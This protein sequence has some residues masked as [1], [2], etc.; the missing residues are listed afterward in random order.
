MFSSRAGPVKFDYVRPAMWRPG[1]IVMCPPLF[2]RFF[3][4][5]VSVFR[6]FFVTASCD[7]WSLFIEIA[8]R[9]MW[10]RQW[11]NRLGNILG[12]NAQTPK[13]V[14]NSMTKMKAF[15]TLN[16]LIHYKLKLFII[17]TLIWLGTKVHHR[18]NLTP[19]NSGKLDDLHFH[20]G[21]GLWA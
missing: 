7:I 17:L 8:S 16:D 6:P 1:F 10:S 12:P 14:C 4:T 18:S 20:G 11:N 13:Q 15:F 2:F 5:T 9:F 3:F 21:R 19:T